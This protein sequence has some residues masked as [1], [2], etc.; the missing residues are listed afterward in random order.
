MGLF[1][2]PLFRRSERFPMCSSVIHR[3]LIA[4]IFSGLHPSIVRG[5]ETPPG[6]PHRPGSP[7]QARGAAASSSPPWI[8]WA[9][10]PDWKSPEMDAPFDRT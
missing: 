10:G 3:S 4:S 9:V 1:F 8:N 5:E 7:L 6:K 2:T